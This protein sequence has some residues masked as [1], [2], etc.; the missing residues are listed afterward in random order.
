M[1][2]ILHSPVYVNPSNRCHMARVLFF[3]RFTQSGS[4]NEVDKCWETEISGSNA[5]FDAKRY[6]TAEF[7]VALCKPTEKSISCQQKQV[8]RV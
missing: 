8:C 4:L 6:A 5:D 3:F 1:L 2:F 7:T